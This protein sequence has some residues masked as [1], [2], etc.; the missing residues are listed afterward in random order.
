MLLENLATEAHVMN[1]KES[2]DQCALD[3]VQ[4]FWNAVLQ[5]KYDPLDGVGPATTCR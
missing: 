1:A 2:G 3:C 4:E 5:S